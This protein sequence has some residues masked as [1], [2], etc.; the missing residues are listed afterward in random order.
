MDQLDLFEE[1][2]IDA[3]PDRYED[4]ALKEEQ[5]YLDRIDEHITRQVD[6]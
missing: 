3:C 1:I 4:E 6:E 5:A 2:A